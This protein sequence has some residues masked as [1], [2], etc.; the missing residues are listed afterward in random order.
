MFSNGVRVDQIAQL[1]EDGFLST[2]RWAA[3]AATEPGVV[4]G[5][6]IFRAQCAACHT[7]GGY[8]AITDYL[9]EDPDMIYSVVYTLWDQGEAFTALAP[10]E[11]VDKAE[12]DY[13]FMPPFVGTEEE[14]EALVEYLA[15]L[16]VPAETVAQKG[17]I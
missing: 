12:L 13:P 16:V 8:L 9:P 10:G 7:L 15:T 17:G 2:A 11:P 14:M 3:A 6:Q 4:T 1:G 5:R